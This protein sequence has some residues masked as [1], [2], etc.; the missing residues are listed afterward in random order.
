MFAVRE[1][2][3]SEELAVIKIMVSLLAVGFLSDSADGD[4]ECT[5]L[6]MKWAEALNGF[7]RR[8]IIWVSS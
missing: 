4:K 7:C 2:S 8:E 6:A 1:V 3:F 5:G